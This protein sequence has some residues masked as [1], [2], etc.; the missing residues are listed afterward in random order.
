MSKEIV[1]T[2]LDTAEDAVSV[3]QEEIEAVVEPVRTSVLRR[4]PSLFLLFVTFGVAATFFGFERLISKS[5]FLYEHPVVILA[6]G[7]GVLWLT[8]TL[9]KKLG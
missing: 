5:A 6:V 9:Y 8:G 3:V 7:V 4:F 2:I 1:E